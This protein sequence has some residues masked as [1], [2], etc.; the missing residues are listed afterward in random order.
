VTA[1]AQWQRCALKTTAPV[2]SE[3][4]ATSLSCLELSP[5]TVQKLLVTFSFV[6][7]L[8]FPG[9]VL[10]TQGQTDT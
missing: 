6:P 9:P 8:P 5:I 4:A 3:H 7:S 10:S 1:A 2:I